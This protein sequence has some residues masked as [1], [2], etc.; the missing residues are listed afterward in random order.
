MCYLARLLCVKHI[1]H[2]N[3]EVSLKPDHVIV[4]SMHNLHADQV[5]MVPDI[6]ARQQARGGGGVAFGG[7][8]AHKSVAQSL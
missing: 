6:M 7:G 5:V 1:D 8:G 4:A 3:V 2:V